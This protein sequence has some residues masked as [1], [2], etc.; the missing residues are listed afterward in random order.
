[1]VY[2]TENTGFAPLFLYIME[3]LLFFKREGSDGG[4]TNYPE[5]LKPRDESKVGN[6][7]N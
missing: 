3:A 7:C 5:L 1:M 2:I 6:L 4:A